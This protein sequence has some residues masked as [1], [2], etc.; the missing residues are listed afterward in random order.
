MNENKIELIEA[1]IRKSIGVNVK[2]AINPLEARQGLAFWFEN[3]NRSNGPIFSIRPSGIKRHIV[4]LKF[5]TYAAPCIQHIQSKASQ[6][7]YALAHA[8]IHQLD[9]SFD[10]TINGAPAT[11][12]WQ[13]TSDFQIN[14]TRKVTNLH[15]S[16]EISETINLIMVPLIGAIAELIGYEEECNLKLEGEEKLYLARRRERSPRNRLLCLSIHGE[17]CGVCGL[18]PQ[19]TYGR[20]LSSILEVHH[21]EPL[22]EVGLPRA[23]N[24][25]TDLIPLCPNCHRAIHKSKPALTPE[26]L[27]KVI[28]Q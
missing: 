25:V 11:N 27:R 21:I 5:G 8:F 6:D 1:H 26:E 10:V 23:Y 28:T 4:T 17:K 3:Y 9:T 22:S 14:V 20:D 18:I 16:S 13:L 19:D 7:D 24:P 12:D 15:N 2:G